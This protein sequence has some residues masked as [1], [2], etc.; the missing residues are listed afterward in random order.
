VRF[1]IPSLVADVAARRGDRTGDRPRRGREPRVPVRPS[2][3]A[4]PREVEQAKREQA[5]SRGDVERD[6][7]AI[8]A[9][10]SLRT[11]VVRAQLSGVA[12]R[13]H[14]SANWSTLPPPTRAARDQL[15]K[16]RSS[17]PVVAD[18]P[19]VVPGHAAEIRRT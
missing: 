7:I 4:S 6:R 1:D 17:G 15:R 10:V 3:A 8:E 16:C 5:V 13:Y 11:A 18:L 12:R 2:P 19:R 14:V 9:A